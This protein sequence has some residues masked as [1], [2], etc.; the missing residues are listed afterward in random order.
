M[1]SRI[2]LQR[3]LVPDAPSPTE[4]GHALLQQ[5]GESR[6]STLG[7]LGLGFR[8]TSTCGRFHSTGQGEA[9]HK[10]NEEPARVS[11]TSAIVTLGVAN[12]DASQGVGSEPRLDLSR[13]CCTFA[14]EL[15]GPVA[16]RRPR[17]IKI[18]VTLP[19]SQRGPL[20]SV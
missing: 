10:A 12:D 1:R 6:P 9:D 7:L 4:C 14:A 5:A 18:V 8:R 15:I 17:E 16:R 19:R 11:V 20:R 13:K 2:Q 3:F